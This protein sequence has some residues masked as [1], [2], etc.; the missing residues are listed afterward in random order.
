MTQYIFNK[1]KVTLIEPKL[2][3]NIGIDLHWMGTILLKT[4]TFNNLFLS[5]HPIG[6]LII[7]DNLYF[8]TTIYKT[9]L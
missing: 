7:K 9:Q 6:I 1:N 3:R 8:C 2:L 4:E 5:Y